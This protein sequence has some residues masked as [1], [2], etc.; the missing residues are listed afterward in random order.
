MGTQ[1][2]RVVG[3]ELIFADAAIDD[4][5]LLVDRQDLRL[6][7][8]LEDVAE[9]EHDDLVA[10]DQHPPVGMVEADRVERA[11]QAQDHVGPALAA[12]RAVVEFAEQGA[13]LG[14][15]GIF[16]AD[17]GGGQPVEDAELA[18]AQPLVDDRPL[19]RAATTPPASQI[20]SAVWRART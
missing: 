14:L 18:L 19:A 17:A 8:L 5:A 13:M 4:V 7:Q 3:L 6:V 9:A 16:L 12:G 1:A 20:A 11:P 15:L 10:D 2:L